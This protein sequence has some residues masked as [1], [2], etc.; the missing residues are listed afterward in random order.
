MCYSTTINLG[1]LTPWALHHPKSP[2]IWLLRPGE[3]AQSFNNNN[4]NNNNMLDNTVRPCVCPES[5]GCT[6]GVTC[7]LC[8][9]HMQSGPAM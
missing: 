6:G 4:N 9:F 8:N 5:A 3:Q 2:T 1:L 7:M